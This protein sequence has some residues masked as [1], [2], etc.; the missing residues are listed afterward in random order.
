MGEAISERKLK[1]ATQVAYLNFVEKTIQKR[2]DNKKSGPFILRD[3]IKDNINTEKLN[4]RLNNTIDELKNVV[5]KIFASNEISE[6]N[7]ERLKNAKLLK[8]DNLNEEERSSAIKELGKIIKEISDS[9]KISEANKKEFKSAM[10][11]VILENNA[12]KNKPLAELLEYC[13]DMIQSDKDILLKLSD[14]ALNW[15]IADIH[16]RNRE[17]GFYGC[18]IEIDD[19]NAIVAFRGSESGDYSGLV[20]DWMKAD[21]GL[22]KNKTTEQQ[23]ET[24]EFLNKLITD[25]TLDKYSSIAATGHSLGGN[26]AT[27]F[28]IIASQGESRRELFSK[29][30]QVVSFDGPGFS[31]EYINYYK[32][33]IKESAS[34]IKHLKWSLVGCLL[35]DIPGEQ[36]DF[37]QTDEDV[38]DEMKFK[39]FGKHTTDSI[40]FSRTGK[41]IRG[42]QDIISRFLHS[43]SVKAEYVPTK[44]VIDALVPDGI[45]R[46][47][48]LGLS[49][50]KKLIN[51]INKEDVYTV[52]EGMQS[53]TIHRYLE[54]KNVKS[55]REDVTTA[56]KEDRTYNTNSLINESDRIRGMIGRNQYSNGREQTV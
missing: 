44:L 5:E 48:G 4:E 54:G 21:F 49:A 37:L 34:K 42:D 27:H 30:N 47:L 45:Q 16:D 2:I 31:K 40:K 52:D 13:D 24:E 33:A 56:A 25:G 18:V 17:N 26:L 29:L 22:F 53:G 43:I 12:I 8:N 20:N 35:N 32:G 11:S 19:N 36:I 50:I 39:A 9:D 7:K 46:V 10:N 3:L 1:D 6:A 28:G 14:E 55:G 38:L 41:A 51:K 15:K 23:K